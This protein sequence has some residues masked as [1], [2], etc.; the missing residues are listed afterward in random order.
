M[1]KYAS[2]LLEVALAQV[3]YLEKANNSNLDSMTGNPGYNN[4]TK[5]AR[6]LD[7][8]GWFY[9]GPKNGY[10]WCDVFVDWCFVT[11]FGAEEALK[12][13]QQPKKSCGAGCS[14]SA[15]YYKNNGQFYT[16]NPKPGD[17]IFFY[18]SGRNDIAHTGL[19]YDVDASYVY[20]V[21]GNTSGSSGVV[22]NGGGVFK[23]K[24]SRS[25]NRIYGYGRPKY[26]SEES[27]SQPQP[28]APSTPT[29]PN[30]VQPNTL[31]KVVKGDSL[32]ALAERWLGNGAK[33]KE[34]MVLNNLTSTTLKIG[35]M[36]KI[37]SSE[38]TESLTIKVGDTVRVKTGAKTY[39]GGGL[40]SGVYKR[41]H[42]VKQIDDDRVVITYT[43]I[44]VAAVKLSDLILIQ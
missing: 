26:D 29:N 9:N 2:K 7:K 37:P 12:L 28:V 44:V 18:N 23:K 20:T 21:E 35:Q 17:Q 13:L 22:A 33:Y 34:I 31:Y 15:N 1:S 4:Y 3:G 25:Y 10:A 40:W 19:V 16:N 42:K 14:Y 32:W 36:L 43:G 8:L 39:T 30:E 27:V 24:Y 41:N 11:A 6:D 5:F 38:K